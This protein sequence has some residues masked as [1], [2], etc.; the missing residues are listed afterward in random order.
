MRRSG[1]AFDN[2]YIESKLANWEDL[3]GFLLRTEQ[4]LQRPPSRPVRLIVIDS[5]TH[6]CRDAAEFATGMPAC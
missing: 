2:I 6:L 3:E 4:L 5:V 1:N